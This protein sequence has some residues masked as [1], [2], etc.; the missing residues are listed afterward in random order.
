MKYVNFFINKP[1]LGQWKKFKYHIRG[2]LS[3]L[4]YLIVSTATSDIMTTCYTVIVYTNKTNCLEHGFKQ[5]WFCDSIDVYLHIDHG[6][7]Y[8]YNLVT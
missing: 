3:I 1:S 6:S 2:F 7:L 5:P 4:K 8:K